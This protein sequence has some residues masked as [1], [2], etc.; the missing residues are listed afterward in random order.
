MNLKKDNGVVTLEAAI[1]V[2]IFII[3]MLLV[4]GLF[5]LFMG[6][7][8]MSHTLVQS[9][10]SMAL[11]PYASQ[12][13]ENSKDSNPLASMFTDIFTIGSGG[14]ISTDQ[15]YKDNA[16]VA[17]TAKKRFVA[18]LKENE[19]DAKELLEEIGVKNGSDGLDFSGSKVE[20]GVLTVR[21]RYVQEFIFNA[22]GLGDIQREMSLKIKL[23]EYHKAG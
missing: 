13:A 12:S 19:T 16:N 5:I 6:N 21:I 3:I 17:K 23:F 8:I 15:W 7:Q 20:D 9:A 18:Y 11:D 10:K 22:A 1:L 2:P 4:N 14:H